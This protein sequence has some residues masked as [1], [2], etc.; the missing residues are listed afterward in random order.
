[1]I[2]EVNMTLYSVNVM[3]IIYNNEI[4]RMKQP[5]WKIFGCLI[6]MNSWIFNRWIENLLN[7]TN[8]IIDVKLLKN[9]S[10]YL[11]TLSHA[12]NI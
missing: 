1:M 3:G 4:L 2:H 10:T 5:Y 9:T 8:S 12:N 6:K 7:G 11:S